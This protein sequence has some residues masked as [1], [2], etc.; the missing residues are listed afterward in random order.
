MKTLLQDVR[1]GFRAL[2]A[3]RGFTA[4]AVLTLALGIGVNTALFTV[5]NAFVLRPL[6]LKDPES[7]VNFDSIDA[8]GERHR[9]FSY[10]D[11]LEYRDQNTVLSDVVAWN[12]VRVT[13]GEAAPNQDDSSAFAEGYQYLFGQIVSDNYFSAL[14]AEMALGRGFQSAQQQ[15]G[16]QAS[17]VLSYS[18]WQRRFGSDSQIVGKNIVLQGQQS[19]VNGVTAREFVGTTPDVPAFW[20]PLMMRDRLIQEGGWGYKRWLTDRNTKVFT[21]LGRLKQGVTRRQAESALQLITDRLAQNYPSLDRRKNVTLEPGGTFVTLDADVMPLVA[22][23]MIGFG[24]VLLLACANVANLLLARSVGRQREIGVRLALG[25]SRWRVVRQL[26][27]ESLLVAMAGGV[28]GLLL[29][30]WT[31]GALYPIV[32]S[33]LPLPEDLTAAFSLNLGPDW[34]VFGFTLLVAAVA[35]IAAGLVP[36]LQASKPDLTTA[37]KDEGSTLGGNLSQ[38]RLRSALVVAQVAVCLSLLIGAGL[39]LKSQRRLQ[40]L[41]TGMVTSNVFSIAVG[42]SA[43]SAESPD[44]KREADLRG[45]LAERLRATP[46][47]VAVSHAY[48]Q[49]LSG[50]MGETHVTLPGEASDRP[51]DAR[52]NFVSPE[53]F[54]ALS[55][56]M[57]R[58]RAFTA[59][60]ANAN[61][62]VVVISEATAKRY[63]PDADPLGKTLGIAASQQPQSDSSQ[64]HEPPAPSYQQYQVIGVTRDVRSRYLWE[65]DETLLYV[66]LRPASPAGQYLLVRTADDPASTMASVRPL[67]ATIHPALRTS[68][69]RLDESLAFQTAPFRALAWLSG[70]LGMLAL[71]LASIGLYGVMSFV[72]SRRTHEIGV[73]VALGA[74]PADVV[75]M[76]LFQ[77]LRLTAM[78]MV[79]GIAGGV[80]ISRLLASV[81]IDMSPLDP[82]AFGGVSVFLTMVAVL[83][84]FIPAR[85]ATKVDPLVA[86]RYE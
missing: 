69:R 73:R 77:G 84:I 14:G 37:L 19:T 1:Y 17:V 45:E 53:Y 60:D 80:L 23:L 35:G 51:R 50:E 54:E 42:L 79:F 21:L 57:V 11:Y 58:G 12:K 20:A 82:I 74:K 47:V 24:L 5:F 62:L 44:A 65:Q 39:L 30:I 72:V 46:G 25:A 55:I 31:L 3:N 36:A 61:A 85:R 40:N 41:D 86:L 9:L 67:A 4:V 26:V 38:S 6:P 66:P 7:L 56:P 8:A 49:P 64:N 29:A 22:P 52:F 15:P 16:E 83:A 33:S 2:R 27:T 43:S 78:G 63:W 48:R 70:V 34:R 28:V 59:E 10:L 71:L 75:R 81:L 76:F 32:L 13:L 18:C 68:V